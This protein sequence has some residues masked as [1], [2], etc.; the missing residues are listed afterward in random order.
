MVRTAAR[1]VELAKATVGFANQNLEA[2]KARFSVGRSTNN[3]V[4]LRQQELKSAEIQVVQATVD[5]LVV[6]D[7]P[8]RHDRRAAGTLPD[9]AQG[10]LAPDDGLQRRT[11]DDHAQVLAG[12]PV[13]PPVRIEAPG[14]VAAGALVADVDLRRPGRPDAAS[15]SARARRGRCAGL[16]GRPGA[17]APRPA[18]RRRR[19]RRAEGCRHL[20]AHLEAA[21]ADARAQRH[22][23][24]RRAAAVRPDPARSTAA[25]TTPATTPRQPAWTAAQAPVRGSASSTRHAIGDEHPQRRARL[26]R[27]A[28]PSA[29]VAPPA[30]RATAR[31][32]TGTTA[33]PVHLAHQE[34]PLDP[35]PGR[36]RRRRFSSTR[37]RASPQA[38]P[39]VEAVVRRRAHPARPGGEAVAEPRRDHRRDQQR[40]RLPVDVHGLAVHARSARR[41][42]S[43]RCHVRRRLGVELQPLTGA[44][45]VKAQ[46]AWRAA[47]AGPAP[48]PARAAPDPGA[49]GRRSR[50]PGWGSPARRSAA[51]PGGSARC[52]APPP[53]GPRPA[54]APAGA[55]R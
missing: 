37:S 27:C 2:E 11:A 25:P 48:G 29:S 8:E 52:A 45:V 39:E 24:V 14:R 50:R 21:P 35:Q 44:R 22:P 10:E 49:V 41:A 32:V 20:G 54:A 33:A 34:Q 40:Q 28:A 31:A 6:R 4:L 46:A 15:C 30:P 53:S 7:Q 19:A 3:D 23:Q 13:V 16:G 51:A 1:R 9:R 26:R 43:A 17:R 38:M 55:S 36:S 42:A 5:L 18:P 12:A 47:P